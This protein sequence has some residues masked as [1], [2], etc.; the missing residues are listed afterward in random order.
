T[1]GKREKVNY[2]FFYDRCAR[3]SLCT[4]T[5]NEHYSLIHSFTTDNPV[6][7]GYT[8]TTLLLL[9]YKQ[10]SLLSRKLID[11]KF[12]GSNNQIYTTMT[13]TTTM[14]MLTKQHTFVC[15]YISKI[16]IILFTT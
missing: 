7:Y 14:L 10:N 16:K 4:I 13:T 6:Y 11:R 15:T 12:I 5:M 3:R 2:V 8:T 1:N 9:L